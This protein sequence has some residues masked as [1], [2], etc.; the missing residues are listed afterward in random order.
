MNDPLPLWS[1]HP[2]WL[3]LP[4]AQFEQTYKPNQRGYLHRVLVR[5]LGDAVER[6]PTEEELRSKP[7]TLELAPPL[8]SKLTF[9]IYEATQH[10]AERQQGTFKVQLTAG[11]RRP[12]AGNRMRFDRSSKA[13]IILAG[14]HHE[15]RL[16]IIWDADLHELAGGFPY[17]KNVQAPPELASEALAHGLAQ[18]SRRLK[19]PSVTEQLVA[20]RPRHLDQALQLRIRLSVQTLLEESL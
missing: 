15:L 11:I 19:R 9:Y 10:A 5:A 4:E 17:S 7:L 1:L 2:P 14:Y 3:H 18:S 12:D 6:I 20:A 16:F 13:R 8:P